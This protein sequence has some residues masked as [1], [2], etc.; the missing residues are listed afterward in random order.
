M[1][2]SS[3]HNIENMV[4]TSA[5]KRREKRV[6][7][8]ESC[9]GQ[10]LSE[11]CDAPYPFDASLWLDEEEWIDIRKR[12]QSVI[13]S[14]QKGDEIWS[15]ARRHSYVATMSRVWALCRKGKELSPAL[16]MELRFWTSIGHSRRGLERYILRKVQSERQQARRRH[17]E[18]ILFVQ[19]QC[20]SKHMNSASSGRL[21]RVSSEKF[22]RSG[23]KFAIALAEADADAVTCDADVHFTCARRAKHVERDQTPSPLEVSSINHKVANAAA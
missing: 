19:A 2:C 9:D 18:A 1:N 7:F 12:G 6:S 14:V 16:K 10:I 15:Q 11:E 4:A 13:D 23:V 20:Y 17:A 3:T 8:V 22:S 5:G 21:L